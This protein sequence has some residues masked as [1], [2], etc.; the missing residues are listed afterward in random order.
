[1]ITKEEQ[2]RLSQEVWLSTT[3][4]LADLTW[5]KLPS[6]NSIK[7]ISDSGGSRATAEQIKQLAAIRGLV[8]DPSGQIVPLPIKSNFREGLSPFEYF[9]S[10][11][12]ARKGLADRAIKT[13]ESGYLTRRLVDVAH[14][15]IIRLEDC[16]TKEG[17]IISKMIGAKLHFVKDCR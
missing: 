4:E 14:D 7:I 15:A 2:R 13:A 11:R 17:L 6:D 9:T 10:A 3:N 12:G 1:L 5:K 8:T 16:G